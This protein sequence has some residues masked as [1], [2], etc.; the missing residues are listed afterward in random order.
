MIFIYFYLKY[1]PMYELS[2]VYDPP[3]CIIFLIFDIQFDI[4]F[5]LFI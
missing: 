3:F 1:Y 4:C 5:E 2:F